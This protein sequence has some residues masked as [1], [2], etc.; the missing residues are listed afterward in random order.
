MFRILVAEDDVNTQ[1]LLCEILR[2]NGYDPLPA[3]DGAQALDMMAR[4][5]VDLAIVDIMMP[6]MDGYELTRQIREAWED[7]PILMLTAKH[8]P[9]DKHSGF[10]AGTDDYMT[11]PFDE[12]ELILRI[13]AL[14]R[15][16]KIARERELRIGEVLLNYD[17]L[18]VSRAGRGV[19]L[20]PKEFYLLFKLLSYPGV[21]FTRLQLMDEIW[22]LETETDDRSVNVHVCRLRERF[23]DYPEFEILTMR[24]LGYKAEVHV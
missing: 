24:H 19:T 22:G 5:Q 10:L 20:P 6:R 21:I 7:F 3:K 8:E 23:H 17:T 11:K 1:K 15:R 4:F 9:E 14:Q 16:A 18:S 2:N 12:K 13:R